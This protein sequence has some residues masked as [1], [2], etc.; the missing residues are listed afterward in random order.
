MW[1]WNQWVLMVSRQSPRILIVPFSQVLRPGLASLT[2]SFSPGA[3]GNAARGSC[4]VVLM[5]S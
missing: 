1:S 2:N 4:A 3:Q 5:V